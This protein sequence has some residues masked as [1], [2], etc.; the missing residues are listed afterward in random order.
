MGHNFDYS[1]KR[2]DPEFLF[3]A[4]ET[5]HLLIK[6]DLALYQ[7]ATAKNLEAYLP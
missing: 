1:T 5:K 7:Q 3:L 4:I 6:R 2:N